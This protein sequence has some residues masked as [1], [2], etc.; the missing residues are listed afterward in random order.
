MIYRIPIFL[1]VVCF[2]S[3]PN[4]SR[5]QVAS[6]SQSSCVLPVELSEGRAREEGDGQLDMEPNSTTVRK[7]G[8]L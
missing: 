3:S 7:P 1:A 4:P 5:H 2:G 8:T 6:F